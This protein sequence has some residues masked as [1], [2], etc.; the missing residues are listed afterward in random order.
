[1]VTAKTRDAMS[2]KCCDVKIRI[3]TDIE[4][5]INIKYRNMFKF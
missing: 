1:M 4:L 3:S 5:S 2:T